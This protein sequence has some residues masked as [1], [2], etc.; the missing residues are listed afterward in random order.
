MQFLKDFLR[1]L[2]IL[3]IAGVVIYLVNPTIMGQVFQAYGA[4]FGPLA[5][6]MLVVFALP[7]RR[8]RK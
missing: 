1:N 8:H 3:F 6:I 2:L 7:R 4:L 5:I